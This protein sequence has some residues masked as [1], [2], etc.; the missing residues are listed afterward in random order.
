MSLRVLNDLGI[1]YPCKYLLT[2]P[3]LSN[4]SSSVM[5]LPLLSRV[6]CSNLFFAVRRLAD[7]VLIRRRLK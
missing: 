1:Q 7:I 5:P 4:A 2:A 6:I 3:I